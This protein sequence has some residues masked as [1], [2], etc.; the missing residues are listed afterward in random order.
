M[1][2][3]ASDIDDLRPLIAAAVRATIDEIDADKARLGDRLAFPENEAA[4]LLGVPR[5]VLRDC[6]LRRE[7]VGA[8]VGRRVVY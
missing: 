2:L 1:K 6:R 7:I 4:G 3:D 5:H 8:R